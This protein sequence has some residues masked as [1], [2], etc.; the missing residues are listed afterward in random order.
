MKKISFLLPL[1][2]FVFS[3]ASNPQ[4][5]KPRTQGKA[6]RPPVTTPPASQPTIGSPSTPAQTSSSIDAGQIV[7][8]QPI[9]EEKKSLPSLRE[10]EIAPAQSVP[11]VQKLPTPTN[12]ELARIYVD[13]SV[14][15][16]PTEQEGYRARAIDLIQDL[17][18]Q[19]LE[20]LSKNSE[21]G[22]LRI[23]AFMQLGELAIKERDLGLAKKSFNSVIDLAPASEF[24]VKAQN[25][26]DNLNKSTRV[27]SKSIGVILP[28]TGKNKTIGER[29]LRSIQMGLGVDKNPDHFKLS[30]IDSQGLPDLAAQAVDKLVVENE[31]VAIIGGVLSREA[32][33]IAEKA[34]SYGVPTMT[35]TQKAGITDVGSSIYRHALTSEIQVRELVRH[36]MQEL[37]IKKFAVIYPNDAYGVEF[38]NIFWDEVLA[39]GGEVNAAQTYT[40]DEKNFNSHVK[41]M[42]GTFYEDARSEEYASRKKEMDKIKKAAGE[43]NKKSA[44]AK[45]E[46]EDLLQPMVDFDAVF[47]PDTGK[48]LSQIASFFSYNNVKDLKFI[49]PNIWNTPEILRRSASA[50]AELIY[51]DALN[52]NDIGFKDSKFFTDYKVT[53]NEEPTLLEVQAFEASSLI[54]DALNRRAY[55]RETLIRSLNGVDGYEG[56]TGPLWMNPRREVIKPLKIFSVINGR[57]LE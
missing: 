54:A 23:Y 44:R 32:Q 42:I 55:N 20:D 7:P 43:K 38:A 14:Q 51:V 11:P 33:A 13:R 46:E 49:G 15:G 16:L 35:L 53:Y 2:F 3:C 5:Y 25:A 17:N 56:V 29:L 50:N 41:R 27:N 30:V 48:S 47:I 52:I 22:Y 18:K 39:R 31:V 10:L 19:E 8:N 12:L 26:I 57:L 24:S 28:L 40:P 36:A 45:V 4:Y 37:D 21:F 6:K 34:Q 1:L 9:N